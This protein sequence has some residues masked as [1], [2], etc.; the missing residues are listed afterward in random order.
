MD[1][2]ERLPRGAVLDA[3]SALAVVA[4]LW[5]AGWRP[6]RAGVMGAELTVMAEVAGL[7]AAAF[8][9]AMVLRVVMVAVARRVAR[10]FGGRA[11]VHPGPAALREQVGGR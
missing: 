5:V 7:V 2:Q 1:G 4:A 8:V 11:R 3:A 6:A 10:R 9:A